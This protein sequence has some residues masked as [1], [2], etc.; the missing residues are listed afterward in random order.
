MT[1]KPGA[2]APRV[3]RGGPGWQL[4]GWVGDVVIAKNAS[5]APR[6]PVYVML[7]ENDASKSSMGIGVAEANPPASPFVFVVSW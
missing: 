7:Y 3:Q 2:V 5:P 4:N 1:A 6:P